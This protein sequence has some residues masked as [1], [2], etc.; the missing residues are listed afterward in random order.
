MSRSDPCPQVLVRRDVSSSR[1]R[2]RRRSRC[3]SRRPTPNRATSCGCS[4]CTCRRSGSRSSA[5]S[6]PRSR[7]CCGSCPR[8]RRTEWDLLAGASAEVGVVFTGIT[9]DR[10]LD[11]GPADVGH[12]LGVGRA[13][14]DHRDPLLPVSRLPRAAPH[15]RDRRRAGQA[16][17]DRGADRVRRRADRA[18]LGHVVAD[19]A[20]VGHR[21]QPE[22]T[23]C[24]ST[25]RWP[26]RWCG[27]SAP[28]TFFYIYLVMRR[29]QLAELEE[30]LE[31]RELELA[32][33][34]RQRV[35][36]DGDRLMPHAW[37]YVGAGYGIATV[38][39]VDVR[40]VD[41]PADAAP[42]PGARR[43]RR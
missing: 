12:V 14:H 38:A 35:E 40:H 36:A 19:A 6:S 4:T 26:S 32:I 7:R 13:A 29:L 39:L 2:S 37:S 3:G 42:A 30:G 1:S 28:F 9:L 33:A 10:R 22:A 5:S 41:V 18:L 24:R 17:R 25:A 27:R 20:P 11:L 23:T 15:R 31:E 8:T 16:L 43:R 34:E 21:V